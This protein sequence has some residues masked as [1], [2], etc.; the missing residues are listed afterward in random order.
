VTKDQ[1]V[2][3]TVSGPDGLKTEESFKLTV[4]DKG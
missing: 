4:K 1:V 2:Y 3:V